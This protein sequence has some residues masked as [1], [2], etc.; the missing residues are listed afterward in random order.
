[1]HPVN[2]REACLAVAALAAL[3]AKAFPAKAGY[4]IDTEK[5]NL[6][7]GC[8]TFSYD[9]LPTTNLPNGDRKSVV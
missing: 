5:Q 8:E 4:A 3:G 2:R 6:L 1:M 9:H 7:S